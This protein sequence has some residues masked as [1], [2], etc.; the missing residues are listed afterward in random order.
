MFICVVEIAF[1]RQ[2]QSRIRNQLQEVGFS[3]NTWSNTSFDKRPEVL[4]LRK[5][6]REQ[7]WKT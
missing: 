4:L 3:H 5:K 1:S 2:F 7:F 6:C